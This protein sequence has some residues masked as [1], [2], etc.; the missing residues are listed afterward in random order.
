MSEMTSVGF[1]ES[2]DNMKRLVAIYVR[3]KLFKKCKFPSMKMFHRDDNIARK[4]MKELDIKG[5]ETF[6]KE[7]DEWIMKHARVTLQDKRS[8]CSQAITKEVISKYSLL[9]AL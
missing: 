3:N 5:P 7:W 6:L 8:A 9:D 2:K 4:V 1:Q